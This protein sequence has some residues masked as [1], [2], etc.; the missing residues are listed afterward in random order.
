ML[1]FT[2]SP[3]HDPV[4]AAPGI[5]RDDAAATLAKG[6]FLGAT[7]AGGA[8]VVRLQSGSCRNCGRSTVGVAPVLFGGWRA[9]RLLPRR[10]LTEALI[11]MAEQRALNRGLRHVVVGAA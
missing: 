9:V 1:A 8:P 11:E 4:D 3:A 10:P 6:Q 2:S 7:A 5:V